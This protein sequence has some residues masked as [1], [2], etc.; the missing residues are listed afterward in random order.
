[1][2]PAKAQ[3]TDEAVVQIEVE[4]MVF[5]RVAVNVGSTDAKLAPVTVI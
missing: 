2:P 5:D 3:R 4:Q 1:M